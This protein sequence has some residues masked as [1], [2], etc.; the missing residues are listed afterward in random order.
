ML[1]SSEATADSLRATADPSRA[2]ARRCP[3]PCNA[4]TPFDR[5]AVEQ[6]IAARF[7]DQ[8]ARRAGALAIRDSA[9]EWSYGE[10]NARANCIGRAL[11]SDARSSNGTPVALLFEHG[12]PEIAAMLGVLKAGR[13]YVPMSSAHP[14]ARLAAILKDCGADTIL[15]N[16]PNAAT[17]REIAH[18]SAGI[19]PDEAGPITII[20]IDGIGNRLSTENLGL[21]ISPGAI[22][23]ILYTSGSTGN[24]RVSCRVIATSCTTL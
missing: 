1:D 2:H 10:L 8:V 5:S 11:L 12:A 18:E 13:C 19:P 9:H 16:D 4:F 20:S 15:T 22:A 17:A 24:P 3:G 14:A 21:P 23:Y 7:E 6:S